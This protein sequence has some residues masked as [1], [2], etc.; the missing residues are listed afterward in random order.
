MYVIT[1]EFRVK[2]GD[3]AR[4]QERV[5]VQAEVSLALEVDCLQFDV[6]LDPED[7]GHV[8]LYEIYRDEAAFR[9]HLDSAH[10]QDFDSDVADWV[11]SK[12]VAA[13]HLAG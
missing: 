4:F 12:Q 9:T 11:A 13:W 7:P 5:R 1:V 2:P 6:C 3:E 8:F 10:F